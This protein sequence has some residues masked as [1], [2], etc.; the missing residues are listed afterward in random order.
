MAPK[1]SPIVLQLHWSGTLAL[2]LKSGGLR[3]GGKAREQNRRND[4]YSR[5]NN[6]ANGDKK[7]LA[8]NIAKF[9]PALS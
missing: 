3:I 2:L 5:G 6:L 9:S 1:Q 7:I 4:R 8:T